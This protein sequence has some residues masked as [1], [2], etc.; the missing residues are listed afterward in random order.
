MNAERVRKNIEAMVAAHCALSNS[1]G[2]FLFTPGARQL[3]PSAR[4]SLNRW[5]VELETVAGV[6]ERA[7]LLAASGRTSCDL[8]V[9]FQ[10]VWNA[11]SKAMGAEVMIAP[12][13]GGWRMQAVR[14]LLDIAVA[15]VQLIKSEP[16]GTA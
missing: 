13:L 4:N 12:T 1:L 6:M 14:E 11:L 5:R 10:E 7:L 16:K 9:E 15:N 2:E 8:Y 3:P